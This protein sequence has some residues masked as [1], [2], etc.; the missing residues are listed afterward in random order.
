ML[1][2]A[3]P[4]PTVWNT[5]RSIL[6]PLHSAS[7]RR[8]LSANLWRG[9]RV[10]I[11]A[12]YCYPLW[13]NYIESTCGPHVA[14]MWPTWVHMCPTCVVPISH[15]YPHV[16]KIFHMWD[17]CAV[18]QTHVDIVRVSHVTHV[19]PH[20]A[21]CDADVDSYLLTLRSHAQLICEIGTTHKIHMR[22]SRDFSVVIDKGLIVHCKTSHKCKLDSTN[23]MSTKAL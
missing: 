13:N 10:R 1:K 7:L 20:V 15:V 2:R 8:S 23:T 5:N 16:R 9:R 17:T 18:L 11:R 12:H 19:N 21:T 4:A 3:Q 6:H 22:I 14:H